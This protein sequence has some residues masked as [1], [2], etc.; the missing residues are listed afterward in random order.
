MPLRYRDSLL[1]GLL[2]SL[3]PASSCTQA[4]SYEVRM[5]SPDLFITSRIAFLLFSVQAS[6][7][8]GQLFESKLFLDHI[9]FLL[10]SGIQSRGPEGF[11]KRKPLF[12]ISLMLS[13][14]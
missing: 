7:P 5:P 13:T 9:L 4:C 1:K 14:T 10:S 6:N 11:K 2:K 8:Q 12:S 3:H